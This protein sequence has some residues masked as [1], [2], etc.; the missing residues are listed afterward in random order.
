MVVLMVLLVAF[1]GATV[2]SSR[3]TERRVDLFS[4]RAGAETATRLAVESIW[5]QFEG[6]SGGGSVQLPDLREFLD[7]IGIPNQ[8]PVPGLDDIEVLP[9]L[10]LAQDNQGQFVI[11][12]TV[13]ESVRVRRIDDLRSTRLEFLTT[14]I[15]QRG[16]GR[17]DDLST[18]H[19]VQ[20]I[21]VVEPPAFEGLGFVL[22]ANNIN[23]IMCHTTIDDVER[24]YNVDTS[25]RG[26]FERVRTGSIE[27]FHLRSNPESSIAGT[28]YLGEGAIDNDGRP[29]TDWSSYSME[30]ETFDGDGHLVENAIGELVSTRLVPADRDDPTPLANLYPK[31]LDHEG[32]P[33]RWQ[34]DG[35]MPTE[36]PQPFT[37]DGGVDPVTMVATPEGAGNRIVDD[38]E[39]AVAL[40]LA[41][42]A[43]RGGNIAVVPHETRVDSA[44][45]LASLR[46][47]A[48]SI[49][50]VAD[51]NVYMHGTASNPIRIQGTL[52]ID[53]DLV[54]SGVVEG[55][56]N[57]KV[58]GNVYVTGDLA[59]NDA[60]NAGQRTFGRAEG[61]AK[62]LLTIA[63]GKNIVIGDLYNPRAGSGA[64][65]NGIA[66]GSW[67][68]AMDEVA[69]FNRMEWIKTQPTLP[70][71]PIRE[72]VREDTITVELL[73][74]V[75]VTADKPVFGWR[76]TGVFA[77]RPIFGW[78]GTGTFTTRPIFERQVTGSREVPVYTTIHHP[79]D[80][81]EPY[82]SPWSEVVQ[83]GTRTES[84]YSNVQ[85]G[86]E[87]IEVLEYVQVGSE[88]VETREW[89]QT[90]TRAV[91]R[92]VSRSFDPP[93][94]EINVQPVYE[95]IT[96]QL[97]NGHYKGPDFVPRYYNLA[98][99]VP[100]PIFNKVG[101]LNPDTGFWEAPER[102]ESWDTS[103]VT[104]AEPGD[105]SDPNLFHP[106]GT[107]KAV[108]SS[109]S[110]TGGWLDIDLL[111]TLAAED[112]AGRDPDEPV[113]IDAWLYSSNSVFGI[114]P[115]RGV[116]G[117]NGTMR[118]NGA[119][120]AADVGLLAPGGMEINF[121]RRGRRLLDVRSNT[122][123]AIRRQLWA[124]GSTDRRSDVLT[125]LTE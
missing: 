73:E 103:T 116:P 42:G 119:V 46:S 81:P 84:V 94:F 95:W 54:L 114:V 97:A 102:P 74:S 14:A 26:T 35:A 19:T 18:R 124:P 92:T 58:K 108:V 75:R 100:V 24:V 9:R 125:T 11:G 4:V 85:I 111:R 31:Y 101:H 82:G 38:N 67:N 16:A 98:E 76:G 71:E 79:A 47:G 99:G 50:S 89:V 112:L 69:I 80:P 122:R 27:T 66:G 65:A 57:L 88:N 63:A 64:P 21:F 30:G 49:D 13:V 117:V 34:V 3:W 106:D 86:T 52:A 96:P 48:D 90:G 55:I 93:R 1:V 37:D 72:M 40:G 25:L 32:D 78:R 15:A 17:A 22:L 68:F 6:E 45:A 83:T 43:A 115:K 36:F 105:T 104:F 60:E 2:D 109:L 29:I 59:Y 7:G 41:R 10:D 12:G 87:D 51:G 53:G 118:I 5:T 39:F 120:I 107:P 123:L 91:T 28:L 44:A 56:A 113:G 121:D 61:G 23:C 70:G 110:P 20:D 8:G 33:T 62:N 77:V